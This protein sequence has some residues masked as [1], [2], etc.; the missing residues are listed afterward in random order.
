MDMST[1]SRIVLV[2]GS[3]S[4]GSG[5]H[6]HLGGC[7]LLNEMWMVL[8]PWLPKAGLQN[9]VFKDAAAVVIY[10]DGEEGILSYPI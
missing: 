1:K 7:L 9:K 4:H 10:S 2:A 3:A 8:K 6:E 5:S